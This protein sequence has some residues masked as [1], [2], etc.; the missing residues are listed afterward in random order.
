MKRTLIDIVKEILSE[1]DSDQ[2]D[3]INDTEESEQVANIVRSCYMEMISNR[4]WP[5]L[6]KLRQLDHANDITRPTHLKIPEGLIE[7]EMFKYEKQ[8]DGQP[9]LLSQDIRYL[10]PDEFL[11]VTGSRTSTADNAKV[12]TDF[13]GTKIIVFTNQ[14]PTYWTSFDDFYIVCDSFDSSVDDTLQ[15]T[16]TQALVYME[17]V[18]VHLND[19]V[20]D[21][22]SSA[23]SQLIEE[24]KSTAFVTLKQST[25]Q[26]AEQKATRQRHWL[27][28]KAWRTHGGVRYENYGRRGRR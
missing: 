4:D 13:S 6:R 21:L 19:A 26:K 3:D 24:A 25:N 14:S 8:K 18:W 10:Y 15:A 16:K 11:R 7:L 9:L 27:S 1:M 12:V 22:P 17:P 2:V 23:F 5:H 28:R 20:P